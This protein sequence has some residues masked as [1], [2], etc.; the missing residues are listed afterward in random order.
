MPL[1]GYRGT[2]DVIHMHAFPHQEENKIIKEKCIKC[3]GKSKINFSC[4]FRG[5]YYEHISRMLDS[6]F[7]FAC[8]HFMSLYSVIIVHVLQLKNLAFSCLMKTRRRAFG[9]SRLGRSSI[10]SS[11]MGYGYGIA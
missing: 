7:N 8:L 11:E 9:W 6:V 1:G 5:R 10:T 4:N 2:D 3:E